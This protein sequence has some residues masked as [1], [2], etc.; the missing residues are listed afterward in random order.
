MQ[1]DMRGRERV[2][3]SHVDVYR[4]LGLGMFQG[5]LVVCTE[6]CARGGRRGVGG[7]DEPR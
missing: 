3:P 7:Q 5:G 2:T 1:C 4:V 6:E